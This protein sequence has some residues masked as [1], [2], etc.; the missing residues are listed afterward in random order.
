MFEVWKCID[1]TKDLTNQNVKD[2]I[3]DFFFMPSLGHSSWALF[4]HLKNTFLILKSGFRSEM[5]SS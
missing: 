3:V 5:V 4:I 1:T 2:E